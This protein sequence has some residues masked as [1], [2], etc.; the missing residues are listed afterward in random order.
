MYFFQ[1]FHRIR[2]EYPEALKKLFYI[3]GDI[4]LDNLGLC[5]TDEELLKN[6]LN[7]VFHAAATVLFNNPL[8]VAINT[9]VLGTKR[10]LDLCCKAREFRVSPIG[11]LLHEYLWI[12]FIF[13][14]EISLHIDCLLESRP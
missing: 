12:S 1:I 13:Y 7:I 8:K 14:I 5:S 11:F 6:N 10:I 4:T 3:R 2:N 9:N